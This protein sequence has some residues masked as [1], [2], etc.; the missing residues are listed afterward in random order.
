MTQTDEIKEHLV[1]VAY[2]LNKGPSD[3]W[4]R[5][6]VYLLELL[7]GRDG[8]QDVPLWLVAVADAIEM[9]Q[10]QGIW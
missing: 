3:E 5:W 1:N 8:N 9:R 4:S 10:D 7:D 2:L 6:I